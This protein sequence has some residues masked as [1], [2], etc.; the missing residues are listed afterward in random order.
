MPPTSPSPETHGTQASPPSLEIERRIDELGD[1]FLA[2]WQSGGRPRIED[3]LEQIE[4]AGKARLLEEL[5]GEDVDQCRQRGEVVQADAYRGRFPRHLAIVERVVHRHQFEAVWKSQQVPRIE[6]YLGQVAESARPAL[7]R[8]LLV[9]DLDYRGRRGEQPTAEEYL[10]RFPEHRSLIAQIFSDIGQVPAAGGR[11]VEGESGAS[12]T[13]TATRTGPPTQ[14]ALRIT[15]PHCQNPIELVGAVALEEIKCPSCGTEFNLGAAST[16]D[17]TGRTGAAL[18][19]R[20]SVAHFELL[21]PL[22]TGAYGTVWKARDTQLDRI[23]AVKIP[24]R[25]QLSPDDVDRF[26]REARMAAQLRHPHIVSVHE[27]GV[28]ADVVYIVSDW[29]DGISLDKWL[30]GQRPG[31]TAS[32][33]L[34]VK[35]AEALHHAHEQGVVH[36]DLKPSNIMIDR[37]GEPHVMDFGLAKRETGEITM[38]V[39]GQILGTPAYM[40]PEQARGGGHE[41]DRRSDVYALGVILFELLAGERPFR[42]EL[43]MLLQQVIND[44]PPSPRKLDKRVHR[45]LETVCLKCLE[46]DPARRYRSARDLAM[47]LKRFLQGRPILARPVTRAERLWRWCR[48][49]P[50]VS[51]LIATAATALVVGTVV[52]TIFGVKATESSR[53]AT[54]KSLQAQR[55]E[56][57]AKE[58]QQKRTESLIEAVLTAPPEVMPYAIGNLREIPDYAIPVLRSR[59]SDAKTDPLCRLHAALALASFGQIEREFLSDSIVASPAGEC[60][61]IILALGQSKG[62]VGDALRRAAGKAEAKKDWRGKARVAIVAMHLGEASVAREML[63]LAP[64]PIERTTLIHTLPDWHGDFGQLATVARGT[65]DATFRSG[66]CLGVGSIQPE[67]VTN[68]VKQAWQPLLSEWYQAELD[69]GV[70]SA[71]GWALRQWGLPPPEI[72]ASTEPMEGREWYVNSVGM[73]MLGIPAGK[74]STGDAM[75]GDGASEPEVRMT[76]PFFLSDREISVGLF[77]QYLDDAEYQQE[78]L[79]PHSWI[80]SS[81]PTPDHPMN[82]VSWYHAAAFCNW[83]SW[84]EELTP[85][86]EHERKKEKWWRINSDGKRVDCEFEADVF[87][88]AGEANG[89]HLPTRAEWEFAS[90]YRRKPKKTRQN[91][92]FLAV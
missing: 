21:E 40:S 63:Q 65:P 13:E 36:R 30:A 31:Q 26:L 1:A 80:K 35:L 16:L 60:A 51:S 37:V 10:A 19:S 46:K 52:S 76:R 85:C 66:V 90:C 72:A 57:L 78:K 82:C 39:E 17:R 45:D 83:L 38:T 43:R 33:A 8:E 25:T 61:N 4:T 75:R 3:Y 7:L 24:R 53:V 91:A 56:V 27:V 9:L 58:E 92:V 18:P 41:A 77:Q 68:E 71:A 11:P 15:C 42:G 34:C 59:F 2:E 62:S 67:E 81:S 20:R 49:N 64:N 44:E 5:L 23:V 28:D 55:S 32:A 12:E 29:I 50:V 84:K 73:T 14:N 69:S 54:E 22:G 6:D 87:R 48:R 86:Y 89:Y 47:E 70:H 88:P 79:K 74:F